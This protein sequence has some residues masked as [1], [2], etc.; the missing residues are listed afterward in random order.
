M[1]HALTG[2]DT[3]SSF[4]GHGKK[5]AWSTWNALSELTHALLTLSHAPSEPTE[6]V[7]HIKRFVIL[8]YDRNSKCVD[9]DKARKKLFAK[10]TAVQQIPPTKAA[11]EQHVRRATYQ[12]GYVWGQ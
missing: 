4:V 12:G 2:C 7:L 8:L 1:F 3:V 11:L 6:D 9:V 10:R 5:K